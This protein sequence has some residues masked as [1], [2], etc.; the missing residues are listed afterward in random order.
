M[1][2]IVVTK[3][4]SF[5]SGLQ[6]ELQ[7]LGHE[8]FATKTDQE[9]TFLLEA[10]TL[11]DCIFVSET[12]SDSEFLTIYQDILTV[13]DCPIVR[14]LSESDQQEE[15]RKEESEVYY[16][17]RSFVDLRD[18]FTTWVSS[19]QQPMKRSKKTVIKELFLRSLSENELLFFN[20]LEEGKIISREE[21]CQK[22]WLDCETASRKSQLSNLAK[23]VNEK[24][25]VYD[26]TAKR[27][28]T[29]WGRGYM[30]Q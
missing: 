4:I 3:N 8:V 25:E 21:M 1:R 29:Y 16:V 14:I 9:Y 7:N 10:V 26:D 22:I 12:L 6:K 18:L 2:G 11:F 17:K 28:I 27:V 30:L 15:P 13:T 20:S 5:E 23:R 19:K 24:L